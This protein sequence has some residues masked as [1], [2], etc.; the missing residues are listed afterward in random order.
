MSLQFLPPGSRPYRVSENQQRIL[1]ILF[2]DG[3]IRLMPGQRNRVV[4]REKKVVATCTITAFNGMKKY[5]R[6]SKLVYVIDR[7][8]IRSLHGNT[9]V[10]KYYLS[11]KQITD[12]R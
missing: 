11:Q 6:K 10:K 9:W 2:D 8:K 7:K 1:K 12:D 4:D 5:L 3:S